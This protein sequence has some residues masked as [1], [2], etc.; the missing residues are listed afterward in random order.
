MTAPRASQRARHT[1]R[2]RE[3]ERERGP[4]LEL[5]EVG[6][7]D[8]HAVEEVRVALVGEL[9]VQ[10]A[11]PARLGAAR[12]VA[13]VE[14][15]RAHQQPQRERVALAVVAA[16]GRPDHDG[17]RRIEERVLAVEVHHGSGW[18]HALGGVLF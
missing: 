10:H 11:L 15:A 9:E 13:A 6:L 4:R 14:H 8:V 3:R 5:V 7:A 12:R 1:P 2:E 18:K 16:V 17:E